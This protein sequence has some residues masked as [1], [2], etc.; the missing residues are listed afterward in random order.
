[1]DKISVIILTYNVGQYLDQCIQSVCNQ[2]YQ[3]LEIILVDD[4]SNDNSLVICQHHAKKDP[5]IKIIQEKN[6]G[7]GAAR[8]LGLQIATGKYILFIDGDDFIAKNHIQHLYE[9]IKNDNS[10]ISCA[11]FYRIDS[12]GTYYF[13]TDPNNQ[14][15]QDLV[16][17]YSPKNWVFNEIKPVIGQI[18]YLTCVK[19]FKHSLFKNIEFPPYSSGEDALTSWKLYLAAHRISFFEEQSYCWRIRSNSSSQSNSL[20]MHG[21]MNNTSSIQDRITFFSQIGILPSFLKSRWLEYLGGQ[22]QVGKALGNK[23]AFADAS[24]KINILNKYTQ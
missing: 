22:K 1:M 10:D 15:D 18:Y 5:R 11:M 8:N 13:Y 12:E 16:G 21:V 9:H 4:G 20:N 19:L 24:Y 23:K 7:A 2:T 17:T 6:A 14:Q 3:D